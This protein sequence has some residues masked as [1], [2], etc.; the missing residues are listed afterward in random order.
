VRVCVA[1]GNIPYSPVTQPRPPPRIQGGTRD[2][3][4]AVQS[5][6][7]PPNSARTL[8]SAYLVKFVLKRTGLI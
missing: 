6:R 1:R 8:P 3:T 4:L 7:V 5:T 2:S